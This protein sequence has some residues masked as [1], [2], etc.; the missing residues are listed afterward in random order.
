MMPSDSVL[1][2]KAQVE[3]VEPDNLRAKKPLA[4]FWVIVWPI[5]LLCGFCA[6]W[7]YIE[8]VGRITASDAIPP[9]VDVHLFFALTT[10]PL[11]WWSIAAGW[12]IGWLISLRIA[13]F[14]ANRIRPS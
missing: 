7:I 11:L 2:N 14:F 3:T 10:Q 12:L 4:I 5:S 13:K 9:G 1:K 8:C 6:I